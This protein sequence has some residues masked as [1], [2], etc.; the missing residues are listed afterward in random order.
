[1]GSDE[2]KITPVEVHDLQRLQIIGKTTFL[3]AF[4]E[5]NDEADM[6]KYLAER[7]SLEHLK[8]EFENPD[9]EFHFALSA[10]QVIG[11]LKVNTGNA[12]TELQKEHALE[13]ERIYVLKAFYGKGAGQLL[14]Q[15]ALSIAQQRKVDFI[16]LGV[17]EKNQRAMRFYEK[18]GFVVF[19]KHLFKFGEDI[20]TDLLMKRV[21]S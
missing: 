12:Q 14:Y 4:A 21:L 6:E 3:E 18:N 2:I 8:T 17:W 20:Q 10:S 11:Y 5:D 16:W 15:K 19:D 13:I 9:S 7:F 1:M